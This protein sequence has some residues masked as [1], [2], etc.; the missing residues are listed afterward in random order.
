MIFYISE[1]TVV[2]FRNFEA[3]LFA[4][5]SRLNEKIDGSA[6]RTALTTPGYVA[7]EEQRNEEI[8]LTHHNKMSADAEPLI[9][10][11]ISQYTIGQ[12]PYLP[13]EGVR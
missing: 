10:T 11:Y 9:Q 8:K 7:Q 1:F 4:L 3:E 6:L 2:W 12:F 13:L 5:C